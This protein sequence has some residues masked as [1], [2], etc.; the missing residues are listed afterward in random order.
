LVSEIAQRKPSASTTAAR[1]RKGR[2]QK[3]RQ[4]LGELSPARGGRD[5]G[6][7]ENQQ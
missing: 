3:R 4:T 7:V 2:G 6:T 5:A 1:E